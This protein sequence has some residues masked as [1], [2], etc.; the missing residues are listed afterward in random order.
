MLDWFARGLFQ[1][2]VRLGFTLVGCIT[3]QHL[4]HEEGYR[5]ELPTLLGGA[6]IAIVVIRLWMPWGKEARSPGE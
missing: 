2:V 6:A 1:L 5:V 3:L 4:I